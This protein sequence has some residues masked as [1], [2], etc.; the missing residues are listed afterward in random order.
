MIDPR[1][2]L[3]ALAAC[4]TLG[5]AQA[6]AVDRLH[7]FAQDIRTLSGT[8]K[9][10]VYDKQGRAGQV[11]SGE[12]YFSRPGRFRWVYRKPY[13]QLIVGDGKK[14]WIYDSDLEQVTVKPLD[15]SIGESPA[16]LLAG[17]NDLDRHFKLQD[18]GLKDG[19]EWLLATPK[20]KEGTFQSVRLGF[21]D[22]TLTA[23][24]LHDN[25]GQRTLLEFSGIRGNPALKQDLFKF[26][27]PKGVDILGDE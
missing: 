13:E 12:L 10:T 5:T 6:D 7:A 16:A 26:T 24:E 27:P 3:L 25:F 21:R 4:L 8:F 17:K 15:R 22:G 11:S 20:R 2:P 23:M 19:L 14:I 1:R 9:Q 18:G